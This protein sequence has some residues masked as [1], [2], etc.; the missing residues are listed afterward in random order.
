MAQ[1]HLV[2][3]APVGLEFLVVLL[4][5]AAQ[6][7]RLVHLVVVQQAEQESM[8]LFLVL[9]HSFCNQPDIVVLH[10]SLFSLLFLLYK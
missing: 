1:A 10:R 4:V 9:P 3:V 8:A 6:A 2:V 5:I 7:Y